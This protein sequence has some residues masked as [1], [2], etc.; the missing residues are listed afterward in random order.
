MESSIYPYSWEQS[1]SWLRQNNPDLAKACYYDDPIEKASERFSESLEWL[2][3]LALLKEKLP[4][5]VLDVGA[6]RGIS[7]YSFAKAGCEVY[8]LEPDRSSL[9]GQGC[10]LDLQKKTNSQISIVSELKELLYLAGQFDVVYCRAALHHISDLD[11]FFKLVTNLL[12]KG[13]WFLATREHIIRNDTDKEIFLKNHA[14]HN[15]YGGENAY[16]LMEYEKSIQSYGL[17]IEQILHQYDSVINFFPNK[18]EEI[19]SDVNKFKCSTFWNYIP[20][21]LLKNNSLFKEYFMKA[22]NDHFYYPG[23]HCS[24]LASK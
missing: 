21:L 13:G 17:R 3:V 20:N 6:G 14:L 5:K 9:V 24:F 2:A 10:I 1:V 16:T 12:R 7:S 15:L 18:E 23:T 11:S 19:M 22:V 8:A 4:G